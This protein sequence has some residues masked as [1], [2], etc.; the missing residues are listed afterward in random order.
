MIAN[1]KKLLALCAAM[2][3]GACSGQSAQSPGTIAATAQPAYVQT[4]TY[5]QP[6]RRD[7]DRLRARHIG[8]KAPEAAGAETSQTVVNNNNVNI[9]VPAPE[10]AAAPEPAPDPVS[11]TP[12]DETVAAETNADSNAAEPAKRPF[13]KRS[14]STNAP[15]RQ[16]I[17]KNAADKV[18]AEAADSAPAAETANADSA[19]ARPAKRPA[20]KYLI[21]E[22]TSAK[23]QLNKNAPDKDKNRK[24][25]KSADQQ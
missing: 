18:P 17:N 16:R 12:A 7:Y 19:G 20:G 23:W 10:P 1:Q 3:A 4:A 8:P 13:G 21:D 25:K 2:M 6:M 14:I 15:A 5:A 11:E 24:N 22:K 9:V